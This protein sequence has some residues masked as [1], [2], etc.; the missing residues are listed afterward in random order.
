MRKP[1]SRLLVVD[2]ADGRERTLFPTIERPSTCRVVHSDGRTP[3]H[4]ARPQPRD[5]GTHQSRRGGRDIA[6]G[7][8]SPRHSRRISYVYYLHREPRRFTGGDLLLYDTDYDVQECSTHTQPAS[9]NRQH[10]RAVPERLLPRDH[11][12]RA[13]KR[14]DAAVR[15]RPVHGER[16]DPRDEAG[17]AVPAFERAGSRQPAAIHI[18]AG[19]EVPTDAGVDGGLAHRSSA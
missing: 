2:L 7:R 8:R 1:C 13:S 9:S 17:A 11:E 3:Q 4:L 19:G 15:R 10:A 6:A 5:R 12:S 18:C 14:R 16:L